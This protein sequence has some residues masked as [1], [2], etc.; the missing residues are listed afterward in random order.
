[1]R[2]VS[3]PGWGW[4]GAAATRNDKRK[5]AEMYDEVAG[6]YE[7]AAAPL[8]HYAAAVRAFLAENVPPGGRVLDLGCGT[9]QMTRDLPGEVEVVGL[10]ISTAMVE[11][12]HQGRP[13]GTYMVHDFHKALPAAL[14]QFDSVIASGAFDFCEDLTLVIGN[15][16]A[17]LRSGGRFY[18]N[19]NELREEVP[20]QGE[21]WTRAG[22]SEVRIFFWTFTEAV[23]AI[24][25]SA[26]R[27]RS[28]VYAPGWKSE[29]LQTTIHCGYWVVERVHGRALQTR[30][31]CCGVGISAR[32]S[33]SRT[34]APHPAA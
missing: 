26:L 18:F 5:V 31:P 34:R 2:C 29:Y 30:G 3:D 27:P 22:P 21:R 14:G 10:D 15:V 19:V 4:L 17:A 28:Y 33:G 11:R 8:M 23:A 1:M 13:S 7:E 6:V 32:L 24:E 9:G 16:A 25:A 12:A 20:C